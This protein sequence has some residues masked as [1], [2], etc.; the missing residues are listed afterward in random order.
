[1]LEDLLQGFS[2]IAVVVVV[3][4]SFVLLQ[5]INQVQENVEI[6]RLGGRALTRTPF[7]FLHAYGSVRSL[8]NHTG[9]EFYDQSRPLSKALL[10]KS[11]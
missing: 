6:S 11:K 3:F 5:A 8:F 10:K 1:M 7:S 9:L 4:G 2:I